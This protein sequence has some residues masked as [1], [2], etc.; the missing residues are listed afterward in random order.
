MAKPLELS[1][2]VLFVRVLGGWRQGTRARPT[3]TDAVRPAAARSLYRWER[4]QVQHRRHP[5]RTGSQFGLRRDRSAQ[6]HQRTRRG[7]V[8]RSFLPAS[9]VYPT[10][11]PGLRACQ[12]GGTAVPFPLTLQNGTN[13]RV[14]E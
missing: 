14:I 11:E 2:P 10:L 12:R 1:R 5:P 13:G 6:Q 3:Y 4:D 7:A 8:S 9:S